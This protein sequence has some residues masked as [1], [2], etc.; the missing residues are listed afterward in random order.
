MTLTKT[1]TLLLSVL[2]LPLYGADQPKARPNE[3][4]AAPQAVRNVG[5]EEFDK[6]RTE[7]NSVVLDVRTETEFKA[8][9]I[10]G[11]VNLDYNSPDFQKKVAELDKSKTYLVH[12][13]GGGRSGR[14]CALMGKGEFTNVVNLAPGFR[15]WEK[16]GKP[17]EKK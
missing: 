16:A 1:I 8:G 6:L 9:H 14:A 3:K 2:A 10:P 11:A 5:V 7:K 15:A 4:A 12:C 13:A 17:V